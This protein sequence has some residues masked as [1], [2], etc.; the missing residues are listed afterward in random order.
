MRVKTTLTVIVIF[1]AL[2]SPF[3]LLPAFAQGEAAAPDP[4]ATTAV[5]ITA[6]GQRSS[7]AKEVKISWSEAYK[8]A[9]EDA[10][11]SQKPVL[12]FVYASWCGW[13]KKM[14][15]ETCADKNI[16][17]LTGSF[18]CVKINSE[19]DEEFSAKY[20]VKEFPC[21]IFLKS[22]GTEIERHLGFKT[23]E[24]FAAILE[25]ALAAAK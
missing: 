8:S 21:V 23:A 16:V 6:G 13:C 19:E 5:E 24:E 7:A 15:R 22:D 10:A 1:L 3:N 4:A 20:K 18:V 2:C 14:E 11:K 25:G 12:L 17:K 9:L